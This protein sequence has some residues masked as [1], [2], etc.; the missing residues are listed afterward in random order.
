MAEEFPV[1][2]DTTSGVHP[3]PVHRKAVPAAKP[4][5]PRPAAPR[6]AAPSNPNIARGIQAA[7]ALHPK[8]ADRVGLT[9]D[10]P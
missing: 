8:D 7:P 1:K 10:S 5:T 9:A 6:P 2:D 4:A 3:F